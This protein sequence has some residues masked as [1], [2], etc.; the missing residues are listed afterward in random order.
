ML[1][2]SNTIVQ[3][4]PVETLPYTLVDMRHV[5]TQW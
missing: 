1:I 3:Y 4:E 2:N 5:S